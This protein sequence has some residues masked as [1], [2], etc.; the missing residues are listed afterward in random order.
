MNAKIFLRKM[1]VLFVLS[2]LF[3]STFSM[4][5]V[6]AGTVNKGWNFLITGYAVDEEEGTAEILSSEE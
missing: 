6:Q 4:V 1:S 2:L 3:L 5:F